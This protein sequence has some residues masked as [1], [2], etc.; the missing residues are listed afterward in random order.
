MQINMIK[1][2]FDIFGAL[3][4]SLLQKIQILILNFKRYFEKIFRINI[5]LCTLTNTFCILHRWWYFLVYF[6][7]KVLPKIF[8]TCFYNYRVLRVRIENKCLFTDMERK[9]CIS[10][11]K[12]IFWIFSTVIYNL[13]TS[14]SLAFMRRT[15]VKNIKENLN[16]TFY[17]HI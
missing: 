7:C 17:I 5:N 8:F 6:I 10:R 11:K 15:R 2:S 3:S 13:I 14:G 9:L 4:V 12:N 1:I 16:K